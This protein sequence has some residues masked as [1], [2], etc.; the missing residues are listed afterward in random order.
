LG[1]SAKASAAAACVDATHGGNGY[2]SYHIPSELLA[3]SPFTNNRRISKNTDAIL[4]KESASLNGKTDMPRG[5]WQAD[6]ASFY[7][8]NHDDV[9]TNNPY[10]MVRE[11]EYQQLHD[12]MYNEYGM[13][14]QA[15]VAP[16]QR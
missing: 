8:H 16:E 11:D 10:D 2:G 6:E 15:Q 1:L 3:V 12:Q 4:T 14:D 9:F 13:V 5:G 7:A